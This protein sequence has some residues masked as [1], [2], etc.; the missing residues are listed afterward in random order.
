MKRV[1][2][3]QLLLVFPTCSRCARAPS[4]VNHSYC[5]ACHAAYMRG[6]RKTHPML[7]SQQF[8]D[9]ARSYANVYKRRGKLIQR[10]CELCGDKNSQMHHPDYEQ[11]LK[12]EWLCRPCHLSLHKQ[13]SKNVSQNTIE[14]T[15]VHLIAAE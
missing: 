12:V 13:L 14:R 15:E 1:D 11:P 3:A 10:P 4:R 5:F 9:N 8:K 2:P 7:P 6:W